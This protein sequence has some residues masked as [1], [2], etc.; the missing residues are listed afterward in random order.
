MAKRRPFFSVV[1]PCYNDGRY[2]PGQYLDR[3][4]QSIVDQGLKK[5]EIE[6]IISDDHSKLPYQGTLDKFKT[7]LSIKYVETEYN[8][9]PG[10]SRQRGADEA[11]GEWLCFIDHDDKLCPNA[12]KS[13]KDLIKAADAKYV[14]WSD[15]D[16]VD[17]E[18]DMEVVEEFRGNNLKTWIHGKFYNI[19]NFWKPCK[20]HFIKDLETHEDHALSR[21]VECA[22]ISLNAQPVYLA[23]VTYHWIYNKDSMSH[24][25]YFKEDKLGNFFLQ[26][27]FDDYLT[28]HI[29]TVIE[30][31]QDDVI[32][33]GV[34]TA[35]VIPAFVSAWLSL[36]NI[37]TD[38][39]NHY[40]QV[41]DAYCSKVWNEVK[42][43]L[44]I[45]LTIM[46]VFVNSR[47]N[48]LVEQANNRAKELGIP[49]TFLD[50]LSE[51]DD[52]NYDKVIDD[53]NNVDSAVESDSDE[54]RPFFS[55]IVPCYN[56]GRYKEGVYLDRLLD[57]LT[58]QDIEREDLEV[59]L[60]DD[61]SP[62]PFF[63]Q[64]HKK[65]SDK[66][67]LKY[68]K[69]DYNCC[70]GNTRG[71][72]VTIANGRWLCFADHDD[73][74]YDGALKQVVNSIT[75]NN[76]IHFAFGDF[77]G[78]DPKGEVIRKYEC[79][80]NWCHAKFYNKDNF[81]DKYGIHFIKDLK[82]HEDI[83]ICTQTSCALSANVPH[84][85]YIRKS[86]YAWTDNPQSVS[87][88][89]YTVETEMG[90]REFLEVFY[91]DYLHATGYV[92]LDEFN[93]HRIKIT[94]AIKGVLEIM[95]YAY[96]YQQ[97]FIFR[98]PKDYYRK[99][100]EIAGE[101]VDK[102]KR[103]FNLD[104]NKIYEVVASNRAEMYYN[105]AQQAKMATSR[106]IPAQ[107]FRQW[108]DIVSPDF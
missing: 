14:I 46:K 3:V 20:I 29:R 15:F 88:A 66:L 5:S 65:Y 92:Y 42:Y 26:S 96:F 55:C 18:K 9:C 52:M 59:I 25:K 103:R 79:T 23:S 6:V 70:P 50:W 33:K 98:R 89:K 17:P 72:G 21:L 57:S 100:L 4:L 7:K 12:L 10:N 73:I 36:Y 99:N 77:N 2:V 54:H 74:Y 64:M 82:S 58:R 43:A 38:K 28:S 48:T 16:K 83:A 8:C 51:I 78:V 62:V 95:C 97:G 84:Y 108:L 69:T 13:V 63:D 27:N 37:D 80:L 32:D 56:D 81:W 85:T 19:D 49:S 44:G 87:H 39:I 61:C 94:Y 71:K 31:Y 30:S 45:N 90:P 93:D 107:T 68:I 106:Y 53:Y 35:L 76:E 41:N 22:L 60:S 102:C 67:I 75:E 11:T 86:L 1:V 101:F 104:N 105:V 24:S 47:F 91:G 40:L 34:A